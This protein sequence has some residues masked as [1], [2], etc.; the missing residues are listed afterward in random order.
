MRRAL[1]I[2][3]FALAA[4]ALAVTAADAA[5]NVSP[6]V[7][8]NGQRRCSAL[9]AP[10]GWWTAAHC[11]R[12][13][14]DWLIR[15]RVMTAYS[16]DPNRDIAHFADPGADRDV[17]LFTIRPPV[18]GERVRWASTKGAGTGEIRILGTASVPNADGI[19]TFADDDRFPA[20]AFYGCRTT[21]DPIRSGDSG[22]GIWADSDGAALAILVAA[23][24]GPT[25]ICEA[26]LQS[27]IGVVVP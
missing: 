8:R 1:I 16:R 26:A 6:S 17:P 27:F 24:G 19:V 2:A 15:G 21:G 10:D 12:A 9:R 4:L 11:L 7:Y 23:S 13:G 22:G 3:L 5:Q 18:L 14:G 25:D 20:R